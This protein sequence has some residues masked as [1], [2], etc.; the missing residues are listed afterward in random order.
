MKSDGSIVVWG[1]GLGDP[2]GVE[3]C[4]RPSI[5]E[6]LTPA[7][8]ISSRRSE[9]NHLTFAYVTWN[10]DADG[11]RL[12]TD[13]EWEYACRA[14]TS[15]AFYNGPITAGDSTRGCVEDP[16]LDRISWYCATSERR[17]HSVRNSPPNPWGLYDMAGNV[18]E[19]CWDW[20]EDL[21]AEPKTDPTGPDGGFLRVWRGGGWN[22]DARHCRCAQK[23][24]DQP[25][26]RY[27]NVGFRVC[28]T[29]TAQRRIHRKHR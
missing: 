15:T 2:P 16:V 24:R 28:R 26:G 3:Y 19:W 14:G 5:S 10:Q 11:Y 7:Y 1:G 9:G 27:D 12:P 23:G 13:A 4:N 21:T 18:R 17:T 22:Y 29:V 8:T 25:D 6:R 20:Y